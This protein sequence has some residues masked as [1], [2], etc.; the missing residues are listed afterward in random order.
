MNEWEREN[1]PSHEDEWVPPADDRLSG[2]PRVLAGVELW[3]IVEMLRTELC[4]L[5]LVLSKAW[6]IDEL[7]TRKENE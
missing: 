1:E 3:Q 2:I 4:G 7:E 6:M 5:Q